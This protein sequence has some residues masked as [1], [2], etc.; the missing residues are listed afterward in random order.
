M[1][2]TQLRQTATRAE[3]AAMGV[4]DCVMHEQM[5]RQRL[6]TKVFWSR[7]Q[8]GLRVNESAQRINQCR[9]VIWSCAGNPD[10]GYV[11]RLVPLGLDAKLPNK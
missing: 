5:G 4:N 1:G 11:C 10:G 8:T 7:P 3:F 9:L 2:C 6:M